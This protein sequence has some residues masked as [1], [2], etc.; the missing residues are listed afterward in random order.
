MWSIINHHYSSSYTPYL[1]IVQ[2]RQGEGKP[3]PAPVPA[4]A[5]APAPTLQGIPTLAADCQVPICN[6]YVIILL[7]I[8]SSVID[9][10]PFPRTRVIESCT[11]TFLYHIYAHLLIVSAACG[12]SFGLHSSVM[13]LQVGQSSGF[14]SGTIIKWSNVRKKEEI[15]LLIKYELNLSSIGFG[16]RLMKRMSLI[17]IHHLLSVW[18][19][20]K[21]KNYLTFKITNRFKFNNLFFSNIF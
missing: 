15:L 19:F 3:A 16:S 14:S 18:T 9:L 7:L 2:T 11:P 4:P 10:T 8:S 21:K 12:L 13:V 1:K 20:K 17:R 6:I 5:P